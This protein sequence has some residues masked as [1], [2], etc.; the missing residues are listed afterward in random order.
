MDKQFCQANTKKWVAVCPR[1]DGPPN[2]QVTVK[3]R[4]KKR[5]SLSANP[6]LILWKPGKP[7]FIPMSIW[8]LDKIMAIIRWRSSFKAMKQTRPMQSHWSQRTLGFYGHNWASL[9]VLE[10]LLRTA[11]DSHCTMH[12]DIKGSSSV[13]CS[14]TH[15]VFV[16]CSRKV[17]KD[18]KTQAATI[19]LGAKPKQDPAK[20][21]KS[22]I[23]KTGSGG[24]FGRAQFQ[25]LSVRLHVNWIY[26]PRSSSAMRGSDML[27]FS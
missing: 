18:S 5:F 26:W 9:E 21:F 23:Q 2:A 15:R 12:N 13:R 4:K 19:C 16:H 7:C 22:V 27:D 10:N 8:G 20:T 1:W 11:N 6:P 24:G 14:W 3:I 17:L 25:L